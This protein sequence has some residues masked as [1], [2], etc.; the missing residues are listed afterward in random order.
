MLQLPNGNRCSE[1]KVCPNKWNEKGATTTREWYIYFRFNGKMIIRKGMNHFTGLAD[2]RQVTGKLLKELKTLLQDEGYNPI[3]NTTMV[4]G[5]ISP[6]THVFKALLQAAEKI[7]VEPRTLLGIK[8]VITHV[9]KAAD[10]FRYL[11]ISDVRRRH[12][13][14]MLDQCGA[15]KKRWTANTFNHYRKYLS[16]LFTELVQL[17]A[18]EFNP[19]RDIQ[20][21]KTVKKLKGVLSRQ[22][23]DLIY[24]YL[25]V[26]DQYPLWIFIHIYFHSGSRLSELLRVKVKDVNIGL[27]RFKVTII[28]GKYRREVWKPMKDT[29]LPYWREAIAGGN[30]DDYV[31]AKGLKPGALPICP[32][33]ITR[34]WRTHVKKKLGIKS[35]LSSLKHSHTDEIATL[36]SLDEARKHNSHTSTGTTMLYA[37]N[38]V[39]R[40]NER[41]RKVDNEF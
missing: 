22:E 19:V 10:Q 1:P 3:T 36:L 33:Q 37:V 8:N 30:Q 7:K 39:E 27:Q 35:D 20:K 11:A 15:K 28:K 13:K 14:M 34:R 25:P 16:L 26:F 12:I 5:E 23:R 17:E 4:T 40:A 32:L 38:E 6:A 24:Y 21:Q 9:E 2:R 18:I 41:I 31:F 29:A